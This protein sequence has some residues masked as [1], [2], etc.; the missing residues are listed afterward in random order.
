M[1]SLG[2][3]HSKLQTTLHVAARI[4]RRERGSDSLPRPVLPLHGQLHALPLI[5]LVQARLL[6]CQ[7]CVCGHLARSR[8]RDLAQP[9][10][11][12]LTLGVKDLSLAQ[13]VRKGVA[14]RTDT[15]LVCHVLLGASQPRGVEECIRVV[16]DLGSLN[17]KRNS[18]IK[19]HD[20]PPP[21]Y[22]LTAA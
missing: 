17:S 6:V 19:S 2:I 9:T 1:G 11:R 12:Q 10:G 4:I 15:L 18:R 16:L 13:Y 5:L 8:L 20:L 14:L 21:V 22:A 7:L 3:Q